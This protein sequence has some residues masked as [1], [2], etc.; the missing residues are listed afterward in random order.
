MDITAQ[1]KL[2]IANI[3]TGPGDSLKKICLVNITFIIKLPS[4]DPRKGKV[5][6]ESKLTRAIKDYLISN[7]RHIPSILVP[8]IDLDHS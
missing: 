4:Y 7:S 6:N 3:G 2:K 1:I 5:L 8:Y